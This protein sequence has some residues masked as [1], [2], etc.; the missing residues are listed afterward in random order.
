MITA[1]TAPTMIMRLKPED[2]PSSVMSE[3]SDTSVNDKYSIFYNNTNSYRRYVARMH[4][5][6]HT[7]THTHAHIN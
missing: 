4:A 7:Y 5:H 1:T 2:E 6:T 3:T